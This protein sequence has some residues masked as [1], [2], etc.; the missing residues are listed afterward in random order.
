[1]F[2]GY[3][4]RTY[5][6]IAQRIIVT[7]FAKRGLTRAIIHIQFII[8]QECT[9]QLVCISP[10]IYSNPRPFSGWTLQWIAS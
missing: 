7:G 8:S 1:M 4:L 3:N 5:E 2:C 10:Q 6:N 9:E